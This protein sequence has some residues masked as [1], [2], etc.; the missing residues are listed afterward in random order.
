MVQ[1]V[2][3]CNPSTIHMHTAHCTASH[4]TPHDYHLRTAQKYLNWFSIVRILSHCRFVIMMNNCIH[5][6]IRSF[7]EHIFYFQ[8]VPRSTHS[9]WISL[10]IPMLLWMFGVPFCIRFENDFPFN[11]VLWHWKFRFSTGRGQPLTLIHRIFVKKNWKSKFYNDAKSTSH[12]WSA[13]AMHCCQ[14]IHLFAW[15]ISWQSNIAYESLKN[16][17]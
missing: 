8:L 9:L 6:G 5:L 3:F 10:S 4:S 16:A 17:I 11:N 15:N 2:C 1:S 12:R 13:S 7:I 14:H